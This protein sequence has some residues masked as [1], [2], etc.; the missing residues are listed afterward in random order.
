MKNLKKV[1]ALVLAVAMV[2]GTV[3][4]ASGTGY[5]D[6]ADDAVYAEAV[7]TLSALNII[8]GDENGNFNPDAT[9]TRA[10]MAKILCT[11]VNSGDLAPAATSFEDVASDHWASGYIAYAKGLGYIDGYDATSFGPEDPV[12]YEQVVKLVMAALGYTYKANEN[13]GYPTGY[14]YVAADA[15]VTKNAPGSGPE[16]APRSTVAI[17][18]NNAMNTPVMERTSYG[19]ESIWEELDGTNGKQF[20]TL[21]TKMKVYKVEGKVT[22]SYKNDSNLK[23]GYVDTYIT[24]TLNIDVESKLGATAEQAAQLVNGVNTLVYTGAYNLRN[25]D[26]TG[27]DAPDYVGYTSS[28]YFKEVDSGDIVLINVAPKSAKNKSITIEDVDQVYD[29]DDDAGIRDGDKPQPIL[30]NGNV[31]KYQF[32]YWNDRDEDTRIT[33]ID[34]DPN[35]VKYVNNGKA[36]ALGLNAGS[37]AADIVNAI[38]PAIGSIT[39]VDTDNDGYYDLI[40]IASYEIAIVDSINSKS[41]RINFK[42]EKTIRKSY[43][44]LTKDVN[45]NL[46]EYTI[47]LDGANVDVNDLAEYDVLNIATNDWDDPT[48]FDIKATRKVVEGTVTQVNKNDEYVV[49]GGEKYEVT[50]GVTLPKLEDE[51]F[52]YLDADGK[53][54]FVKTSSSVSGTYGYLYKTGDGTFDETYLRLFTKDG[55]DATYEIADKI[56]I[57]KVNKSSTTEQYTG[58]DIKKIFGKGDVADGAAIKISDVFDVANNDALTPSSFL[59]NLTEGKALKAA[60]AITG[61]ANTDRFITYKV[62]SSNKLTEINLA[63]H[64]NNYDEFGYIG[65]DANVEWQ[66]SLNKF[67]TSKS[68][69]DNAIIFFVDPDETI[70]DYSVK[71]IAGLVDGNEYTPYYF[72]NT[73]NG[74]SAILM[75][76]TVSSLNTSDP[77][78]IFVEATSAK[79]DYDD[80]YNVTYWKDGVKVSEPLVVNDAVDVTGKRA[81]FEDLTIGD[82]FLYSLDQDGRVDKIHVVFAPGE[83][84]IPFGTKLMSKV[85]ATAKDFMVL[86]ADNKEDNE[87][88]FGYVSKVAS[89]SSGVRLTL[90]DENGLND[91]AKIV[92]VPSGAKV[93][94][95]NAAMPT[96]KKI[97]EG[98]TGDITASFFKKVEGSEDIDFAE[99]ELDDM[100]Y[101]FVRVYKDVV[102]EV[103][104]VRYARD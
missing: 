67:K 56:K 14:L 80:V 90:V 40:K 20:K 54:A 82:A 28:L 47:T 13:G 84:A 89:T 30:N 4:F 102:T 101:A 86:D 88:Y 97:A 58:A 15:D 57:N 35:A 85:D 95:Y 83:N 87:V 79:V 99:T 76:D 78:A 93:T 42:A 3:A 61:N 66:A 12:T 98:N 21:L 96:A 59:T 103:I 38:T 33:T 27:T 8:K 69:A 37:N 92:N 63:T 64:G 18:V 62:D 32:S 68:I 52:F 34:I 43:I 9:I 24:K 81:K 5:P 29:A 74:P 23:D 55:A 26:A 75:L 73:D 50:N 6:V 41:N 94:V 25:I 60:Y 19:T 70:S 39:F 10:E 36:E 91:Q 51:G 1:L 53:I 65:T 72:S 31:T 71:D 22:N 46:K 7:K 100:S 104:Y 16:P 49:I 17:I 45:K 11:M 44:A 2:F 77:F 48:Y